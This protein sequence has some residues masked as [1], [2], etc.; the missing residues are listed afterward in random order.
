MK[1]GCPNR[2][3][4]FFYAVNGAAAGV[5]HAAVLNTASNNDKLSAV[6]HATTPPPR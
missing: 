6:I 5:A 4:R 1:N 3:I 2:N